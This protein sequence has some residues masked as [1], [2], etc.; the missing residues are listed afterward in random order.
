MV[1]ERVH[2]VWAADLPGPVDLAVR[3]PSLSLTVIPA[4]R[5]VSNFARQASGLPFEDAVDRMEGNVRPYVRNLLSMLHPSISDL[6]ERSAIT[7]LGDP[8]PDELI[9]ALDELEAGGPKEVVERA[10][11]ECS[12]RLP[13]P[14]LNSRVLLLPGDGHSRVLAR[15]MNGVLGFSLGAQAMMVFLWPVTGWQKWLAYTVSH[16]YVHLVR[17]LLFPRGPAGGK[18]IYVKT[19]EPETL[20]DALITEG[21]A[22]VFAT[23]AHGDVSPPWIDALK[24]GANDGLWARVHRR[25][26]VSDPT[27]IRRILFGDNDRVPVWTG[28][29]VGYQVVKGYLQCNPG[30]QSSSLVSLPASTIFKESGY[31]PAF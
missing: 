26:S 20:L 25:L 30:V 13:R 24:P 18:L 8:D 16:E 14:D 9:T 17:N 27:E 21:I 1:P 22:D 31:Q 3:R 19:Q 28:Y 6:G 2:E 4:Y 15:Q 11:A 23:E 10:L 12:G 7:Q 5:V 29:T